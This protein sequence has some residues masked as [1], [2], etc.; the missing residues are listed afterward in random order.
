M[1]QIEFLDILNQVLRLQTDLERLLE[2]PMVSQK[3]GNTK[4]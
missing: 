3:P 2:D 1:S 4:P